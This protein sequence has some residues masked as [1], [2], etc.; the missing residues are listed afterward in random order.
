MKLE[1]NQIAKG[2]KMKGVA[3]GPTGQTGR[4]VTYH[5]QNVTRK[6]AVI[7]EKNKAVKNYLH[8]VPGTCGSDIGAG[9]FKKQQRSIKENCRL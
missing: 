1:G 9:L 6:G 7:L 8:V 5:E 3:S 2:L 4:E